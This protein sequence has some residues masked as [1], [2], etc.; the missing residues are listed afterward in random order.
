MADEDSTLAGTYT[1]SQQRY[2]N[3]DRGW[4][5]D[6]T[7]ATLRVQSAIELDVQSR[8]TVRV[9]E[10]QA[11]GTWAITQSDDPERAA[12]VCYAHPLQV[13]GQSRIAFFSPQPMP[14][15]VWQALPKQGRAFDWQDLEGVALGHPARAGF[16]WTLPKQQ[17]QQLW[18]SFQTSG[19]KMQQRLPL[20]EDAYEL[21]QASELLAAQAT[22]LLDV[23]STEPVVPAL[24]LD[25]RDKNVREHARL[26]RE[27]ASCLRELRRL[28]GYWLHVGGD[29]QVQAR[30]YLQK[31]ATLLRL[32]R[33][34]IADYERLPLTEMPDVLAELALQRA[35]L[36]IKTHVDDQGLHLGKVDGVE[37]VLSPGLTLLKK[38]KDA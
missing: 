31:T 24:A 28:E 33:R 38:R 17:A 27:R 15:A 35:A 19:W 5:R 22:R 32:T 36:G 8:V 3:P 9:Q 6:P 10:L 26:L 23:A 7:D 37:Y 18:K 29:E 4:T 14:D 20:M 16:E 2:W 13:A 21:A 25:W 1:A 11:D 30:R 34:R 12:R